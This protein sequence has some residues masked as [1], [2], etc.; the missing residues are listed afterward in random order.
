MVTTATNKSLQRRSLREQDA[1][2]RLVKPR[3]AANTNGDAENGGL[4][5]SAPKCNKKY[6]RL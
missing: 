6:F 1:S 4:E 5:N 2:A 3:T